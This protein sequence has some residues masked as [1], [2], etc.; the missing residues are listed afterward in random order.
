MPD[1]RYRERRPGGF[2]RDH[3]DNRGNRDNRNRSGVS[4]ES[5][6]DRRER[7][8]RKA[9]GGVRTAYVASAADHS[10]IQAINAYV[11][12]DKVLNVLYERLEEWY[13][14]YFPNIRL[15]NH[16]QY[17]RLISK[18]GSRDVEESVVTEIMGESGPKIFN[19]I[20][21]ST[22]F[23]EID[24][25]EYKG[26][27]ALAEEE[28][29]LVELQ[30]SLDTFLAAQT[31]KV[32]PNIVYLID[33]KI[34]AEMLA[35]AGSL[36]RFANMPASTIQLLGAERALFKHLKFGGR[37]PK[38]GYLFKLPELA[39]VNKKEK[40]RLARIYATKISIAARADAF[41][42]RFIADTLKV[43]LEK[44]KA[45]KGK[46]GRARGVITLTR[47]FHVIDRRHVRDG[48]R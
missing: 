1:N 30:K 8:M 45:R 33:Y 26:L 22:G 27:K 41:S 47:R 37:P 24:S 13:G 18:V 16:E 44:A 9:K 34:A 25:E 48:H 21:S 32:M 39:T 29:R 38:Y 23:A 43:Q 15:G 20:K 7:F 6:N 10:I 3:R 40:G 28:L 5:R 17:A 19:V 35:K 4:N 11:E 2:N 14:A 36:E 31:K 42:K 12:V 46:A